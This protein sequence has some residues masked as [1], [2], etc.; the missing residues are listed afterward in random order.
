MFEFKLTDNSRLGAYNLST[1]LD[2]T[3]TFTQSNLLTTSNT[4][5]NGMINAWIASAWEGET[6]NISEYFGWQFF[7][8]GTGYLKTT[9]YGDGTNY[10]NF[11]STWEI[12]NGNLIISRL[13]YGGSDSLG[14][15]RT[16]IPLR[17]TN[18]GMLVFESTKSRISENNDYGYRYPPRVNLE[19]KLTFPE[20][21]NLLQNE[22]GTETEL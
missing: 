18:N 3:L 16:W 22:D 10:L 6:L 1:E 11:P 17:N 4:A 5:W 14:E 2:P 20:L 12:I 15:Q 19:Q 8:D 9:T 7:S 21:S 13:P